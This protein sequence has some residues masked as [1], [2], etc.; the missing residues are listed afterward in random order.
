LRQQLGARARLRDVARADHA[1]GAAAAYRRDG[2][3]RLW[4]VPVEQDETRH[5]Q[6]FGMVVR[7][8]MLFAAGAHDFHF[9]SASL[10]PGAADDSV[11]YP[12]MRFDARAGK[13]HGAAIVD[14]AAIGFAAIFLFIRRRD[15]IP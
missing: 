3:G 10:D 6:E 9:F 15:R 5:F 7:Q 8:G 12:A 1:A 13:P 11:L 4:I 14:G 2:F